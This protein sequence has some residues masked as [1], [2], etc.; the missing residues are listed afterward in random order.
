ML[1]SVLKIALTARALSVIILVHELG[2]FLSFYHP[3][4]IYADMNDVIEDTPVCQSSPAQM[5][6]YDP[7][8]EN[9]MFPILITGMGVEQSLSPTQGQIMRLNP[10]GN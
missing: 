10:R 9:V 1:D 2:H 3:T 8:M 6:T 4:E 5:S 7:C